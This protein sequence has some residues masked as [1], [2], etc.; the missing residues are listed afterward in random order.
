MG[1]VGWL[2]GGDADMRAFFDC[3]HSFVGE[4]DGMVEACAF[5]APGTI[6][7]LHRELSMVSIGAVATSRVAR[8]QGL[9]AEVTAGT[10]AE[11]AAEGVLVAGLGMFDQ[12]FYNRLGFGTGPYEL[13]TTFD[14]SF[15]VVEA[16]PRKPER[17]SADDWRDVHA[18][19]L[20]RRRRHGALNIEPALYTRGEMLET[21]NGFGL[22]YRDSEGNLTH[23][24]WVGTKDIGRGPYEVKWMAWRTPEQFHELMG[25]V[26]GLGDQVLAVRMREPRGIQLQDLLRRPLY[27]WRVAEGTDYATGTRALAYWQMRML[28]LPGCLERTELSG[29]EVR[30]NLTITDPIARHL[31]DTAPWRGVAGDY[32]VCLGPRCSA[33]PGHEE[34]LP[35]LG[36]T[37]NAFTRLWLG[38]L[39][40]SGLAITDDL[41]AAPELIERLDDVLHMPLPQPDW[42]F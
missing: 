26:K 8:K 22:G 23:H 5:A 40:A 34:G 14:P 33:E 38:V 20:T 2:L 19:R 17:L 9:A 39:P 10:V 37:V 6:R 42:E 21:P 36:T 25:L 35:E 12:G 31:P 16:R 41:K 24:M 18:C 28:D 4:L 30:F 11:V 3:G 27:R 32:V 13:Q 7:H 15:L 29:A 1:E